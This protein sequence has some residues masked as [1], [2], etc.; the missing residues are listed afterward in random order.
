ML[1]AL[2]RRIVRLALATAMAVVLIGQPIIAIPHTT[3]P[4]FA[5]EC[6]VGGMPPC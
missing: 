5:G 6:P 2:H 3:L 1:K 4:V